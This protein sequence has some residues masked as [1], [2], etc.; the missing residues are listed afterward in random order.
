M[1]TI[2]MSI[3]LL[4]G[5]ILAAPVQAQTGVDDKTTSECAAQGDYKETSFEVD[6]NCSMCKDRI[7][8]AA[9]QV[10]G[11]KKASWNKE[12][13]ML[14][15]TYHHKDVDLDDVHQKI[16]GAGHDTPKEKATSQAYQDLPMCCKYR[17]E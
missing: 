13:H 15:L 17:D 12:N 1:K 2:L 10:K 16:A 6:G 14:S 3:T 7:E 9:Q 8:K 4:L 5:I 11:V